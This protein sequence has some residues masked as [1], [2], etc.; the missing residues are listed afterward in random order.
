MV[1]LILDIKLIFVI[2]HQ[3]ANKILATYNKL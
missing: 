3:M 1:L 2:F